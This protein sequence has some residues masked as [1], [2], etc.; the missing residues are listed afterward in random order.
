MSLSAAAVLAINEHLFALGGSQDSSAINLYQPKNKT[1]IR[2]GPGELPLARQECVC[3]VL[4]NQKVLI[5]GGNVDSEQVDIGT[6][7]IILS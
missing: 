1:W 7:T 3:T 2:I 4:P 5:V 6:F